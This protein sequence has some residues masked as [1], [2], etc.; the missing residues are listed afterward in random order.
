MKQATEKQ[1]KIMR[2][3]I[4]AAAIKEKGWDY[5]TLHDLMESWGFGNSLKKL[6]YGE[7]V[8]VLK[9]I[10]DQIEPGQLE[11][12]IGALDAQ[13]RYMWS[14]MKQAGWDFAR[15]RMWMLKH[16]SASHWNALRY[17]EKRA[18]I[19]MLKN[20]IKK[21]EENPKEGETK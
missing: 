11:Y 19:A 4:M 3:T 2:S 9:I 17:D 7:L 5:D 18:V 20:Y 6:S 16:C 1:L 12:G 8:E 14:L 13:G 10:R 15:L 21:Q